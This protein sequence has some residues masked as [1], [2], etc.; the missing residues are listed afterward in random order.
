MLWQFWSKLDIINNITICYRVMQEK[1]FKCHIDISQSWF[2][3]IVHINVCHFPIKTFTVFYFRIDFSVQWVPFLILDIMVEIMYFASF[4]FYCIQ[5][6]SFVLVLQIPRKI[7]LLL[8]VC[9]CMYV[10]MFVIYIIILQTFVYLAL[11]SLLLT[12]WF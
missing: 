11:S 9:V 1:L 7:I 8:C 10:H 12:K 5:K 2:C 6:W 3:S 4:F